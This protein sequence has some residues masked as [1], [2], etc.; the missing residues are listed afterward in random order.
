[1]SVTVYQNPVPFKAQ[2]CLDPSLQ[3]LE[4]EGSPGKAKTG[5]DMED[6]PK[7]T[8]RIMTEL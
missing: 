3:P 4:N 6:L 2:M 8:W 7:V 5:S 1:M